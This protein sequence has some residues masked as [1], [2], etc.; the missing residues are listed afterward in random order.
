MAIG[1]RKHPLQHNNQPAIVG[2]VSGDT[3]ISLMEWTFGRTFANV[4][5]LYPSVLNVHINVN[6]ALSE[7][8]QITQNRTFDI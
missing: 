2:S 6:A 7:F 1:K 4:V 8:Q 5:S 3:T